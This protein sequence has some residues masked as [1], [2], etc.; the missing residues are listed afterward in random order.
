[1]GR[2]NTNGVPNHK[3]MLKKNDIC[4]LVRTLSKGEKLSTN[5]K[6]RVVHI[7]QFMIRVQTLT[8]DSDQPGKRQP[9]NTIVLPQPHRLLLLT[10]LST[11]KIFQH[12]S[13][14][15]Q[16]PI[17]VNQFR[18]D[19]TAVSAC[20]GLQHYPKQMSRPNIK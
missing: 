7:T 15:V 18:N 2:Y 20:F 12:S 5:T 3:L 16:I 8:D 6:V 14:K 9:A 17:Q 13:N 11:R 4:L 1:M 19:E 10:L